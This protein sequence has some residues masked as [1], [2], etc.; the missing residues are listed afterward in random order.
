MVTLKQIEQARIDTTMAEYIYNVIFYDGNKPK[1][2]MWLVKKGVDYKELDVVESDMRMAFMK[3]LLKYNHN[4]ISFEKYVWTDFSQC[5][6]NYFQSKKEKKYTTISF[7]D[8]NYNGEDGS[9]Q[10]ATELSMNLGFIPEPVDC[11]CDFETVFHKLTRVQATICRMIYYSG[12]NKKDV[13]EYLGI[14]KDKYN[15]EMKQVRIIF[16]KYL[17]T[18]LVD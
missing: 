13:T 2:R 17:E 10:M 5:L 12:W 16:K 8:I 9:E 3:V 4:K 1:L 18:G 7:D 14:N 15:K 11:K 6:L